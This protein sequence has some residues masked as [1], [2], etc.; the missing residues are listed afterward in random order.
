[1]CFYGGFKCSE[2]DSIVSVPE[3]IGIIRFLRFLQDLLMLL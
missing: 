2:T 1:M 3:Q